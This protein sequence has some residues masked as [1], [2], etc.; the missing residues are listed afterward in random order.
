MSIAGTYDFSVGVFMQKNLVGIF[1]VIPR[2]M[3]VP[4]EAICGGAEKYGEILHLHLPVGGGGR[5][6]PTL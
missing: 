5:I 3:C 4:G 1:D 2:D 6:D